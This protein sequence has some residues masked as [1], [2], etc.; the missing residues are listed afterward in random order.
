MD[1]SEKNVLSNLMNTKNLEIYKEQ[2][3]H[4]SLRKILNELPCYYAMLLDK[5]EIDSH[6]QNHTLM[7]IKNEML[8]LS[9]N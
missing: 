4:D 1:Y 2:L 6:T 3:E 8:S 7:P 9:T 5:T